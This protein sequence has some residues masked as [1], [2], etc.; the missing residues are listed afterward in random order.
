MRIMLINEMD[1]EKKNEKYNIWLI[2]WDALN[3]YRQ[4]LNAQQKG[5]KWK[6]KKNNNE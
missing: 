5:T 6:K 4:Y 2:L 1:K 3:F